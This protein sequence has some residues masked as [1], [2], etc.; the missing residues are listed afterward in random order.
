[1][2]TIICGPGGDGLTFYTLHI[3]A[4]KPPE[5]TRWMIADIVSRAAIELY[6]ILLNDLHGRNNRVQIKEP[7]PVMAR[8]KVRAGSEV[9]E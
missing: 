3:P 7:V 5:I 1:M 6:K 8:G 9:K 4:Q 2:L